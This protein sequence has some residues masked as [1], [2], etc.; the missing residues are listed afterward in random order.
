MTEASP[1]DTRPPGD[2]GRVTFAFLSFTEVTEPSAHRAYNEWHQLDHLPEQHQLPGVVHG[3]RWVRTPACA[4]ASTADPEWAATHYVTCYLMTGPRSPTL[5]DFFALAQRLRAAGRFF[6]QRRALLSGPFPVAAAVAAPR[7]SVSAAVVPFR[8][9][10]GAYVVVRDLGAVHGNASDP[11]RQAD[12]LA[13]VAG[14][15]GV[16]A[17]G[18]GPEAV[19]AT[20]ARRLSVL[21]CFLDDDPLS[22]A[23]DAARAV[24][25]PAGEAGGRLVMASPLV[26]VE[27]WHWDWFD[28]DRRGAGVAGAGGGP[29]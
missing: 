27:P 24:A 26:T 3:Q 10:R 14:V 9:N 22:V 8:P 25:A 15:A 21:L 2:P 13:E 1:T 7:V 18:P 12:R 6:E 20:P 23:P 17:F 5:V 11:R 29:A 16:W 28:E 4:A 19:G